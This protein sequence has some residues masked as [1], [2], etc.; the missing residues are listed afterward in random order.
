MEYYRYDTLESWDVG[1]ARFITTELENR[2][3]KIQ[4]IKSKASHILSIFR[5]ILLFKEDY[6]SLSYQILRGSKNTVLLKSSI[7]LTQ[8]SMGRRI[9]EKEFQEFLLSH[10][11]DEFYLMVLLQTDTLLRGN[12]LLD[13]R[14]KNFRLHGINLVISV[15]QSKT[16]A[17]KIE[18]LLGQKTRELVTIKLANM[19]PDQK[20]FN[21]SLTEYN[22]LLSESIL[23]CTSHSL[24]AYG[25][26]L[27]MFLGYSESFVQRRGNWTSS[28]S[29]RKYVYDIN[30]G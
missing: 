13:L 8:A 27:L 20:L 16:T 24:R 6:F 12:N 11:K 28:S 30:S 5:Q 10:P 21:K 2:S 3:Y 4:T 14:H 19:D 1:L 26:S 25:A 9:M 22:R 23:A 29:F 7:P 18:G 15:D 17:Y